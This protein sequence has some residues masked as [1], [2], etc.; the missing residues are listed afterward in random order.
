M[1]NR[2]QAYLAEYMDAWASKGAPD[3]VWIE[4]IFPRMASLKTS[5]ADLAGCDADE[6]AITTNISI[7]LATIASCLDFSGERRRVILSELDFPTDGHVWLAQ[8]RRGAELVWLKSQDGLTIPL[9]GVRR[10]R[11]TSGPRS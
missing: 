2:S 10:A 7:A 5:F 1:S 3:H 6:L 9:G 11:S 4:D 8:E